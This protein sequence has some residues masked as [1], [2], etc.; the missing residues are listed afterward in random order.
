M[1]RVLSYV[2]IWCAAE[3]QCYLSLPFIIRIINFISNDNEGLNAI[4]I[5]YLNLLNVVFTNW[6]NFVFSFNVA[7][8]KLISSY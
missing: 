1:Y 3:L 6:H 7:V 2:V 4:N 5:I 8:N